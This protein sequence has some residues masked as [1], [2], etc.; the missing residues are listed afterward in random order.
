V[1][2]LWIDASAGVAGDMLLGALVDAG[3]TLARVQQ[4]VDAV[5]PDG[6]RLRTEAVT[7]AGLRAIR[8]HV[9]SIASDQSHRS[10]REIRERLASASLADPVRARATDV[11]AHLAAAEAAVHGLEPD[12]VHFHEVGALDSIADV[13]GVSAALH[14][15]GITSVSAGAVAVGSGRM[16]MTH[17]DVGVPVPAVVELARDWRIRSGGPGELATPTGMALVVVLS[18]RCEELPEL[19]LHASG[20][21]AG[22]RDVP[23]RA[24]VTRVIIGE[25]AP[26]AA[27]AAATEPAI[28]LEA[29]VDDLDPR[30]WPGVLA[31]LLAAGASD[32]WLVP[33]LMKKGR[34]AHILSVLCPPTEVSRLREMIFLQ[35]S[36]IGVREHPVGKHALPRLWVEVEIDREPVL[37][38]VAHRSGTA[39]QVTP[40]FDSVAAAADRL[41]R[42]PATVLGAAARMAAAA[43]LVAGEPIPAGLDVHSSEDQRMPLD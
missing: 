8:A 2:H 14:D 28:L 3:A 38:K 27:A 6:V 18:E 17:G 29:N 32:A 10:W 25:R 13:V 19:R 20:T 26:G 5:V 11:F 42:S 36:T 43:G 12:D 21:G 24:N 41:R 39:L 40:E 31:T 15:L 7:R 23:G 22:S 9:E 16:T 1:T 37:I 35:T 34:P 30:L 33:I 4:A